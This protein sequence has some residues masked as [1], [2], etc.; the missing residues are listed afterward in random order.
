MKITEIIIRELRVPLVH[1]YA[2]SKAYGVQLDTSNIVVE[3]HTD[4]GITGWGECDPWPAFTGDTPD[5]VVVL[6]EKCLAPVLIGQD[7]TNINAI[8]ELMDKTLRANHTSKA[9]IDMACHDIL[10]KS[11]GV[12]VHQ[13]IGGRLRDKIRCFWAV[14]GSTPE[15][16]AQEIL[17]IK[18]QGFWGCM[19]KIGT[20][21]KLDAARTLAARDAVGED[22]PLIADA[23]Q[24]WDVDTAV[25]YGKAVGKANLLFFEQPVKYWD[26]EGLA[27]I[28]RRVPMAVSADEGVSTI[29]EAKALIAA[30]ACDYFSIKVSKHGGIM[31]TKQICEYADRFGIKLFFNSML[32][33]GITQVSSLHVASTVPNILM[34]TGHSFFSTLRLKGDITDFCNWTKEGITYV[35]E[36]PGLGFEI[37]QE[38]LD[39]FTVRTVLAKS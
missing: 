18:K 7:P 6:L 19:I 24:G 21:W 5:S 1:A 34:S 9:G 2:L 12:P 39:K 27:K 16:T 22:F 17:A 20:D 35:P 25:S 10:G 23:N 38:N 28:R 13:L 26:V 4:E 31:K 29:Q 36:K 37:D 30:D 3:V 14:G 11:L 32:E 15:E 8:H 33:E